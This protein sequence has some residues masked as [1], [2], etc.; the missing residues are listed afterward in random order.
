MDSSLVIIDIVSDIVCPWC[1]LGKQYLDEAV[2]NTPEIKVQIN[3][4]PFMLDPNVPPEGVPYKDYMR[5][6][7]GGAEQFGGSDQGETDRFKS[8]RAHLETAAKAAGIAF[9]FNN[10][11]IRPNTLKAHQLM[12]WAAGQNIA[13]TASEALFKAFFVD[14]K[15]IGNTQTLTPIAEA[16]GMDGTLVQE[17]LNEGRDVDSIQSELTYFQQLG[18]SSVP[19]FIYN[20]QFAVQGGQPAS[21][22]QQA[23]QKASGL[24]PKSILSSPQ[25]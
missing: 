23:L 13:H 3:W 15:D 21:V 5:K 25:T 18:I 22:H 6:K 10:I 16:I 24:T 9:D 4:H 12:K 1:W 2:R 8:I 20:G 19:T 7:F 14:G 17:L 11:S